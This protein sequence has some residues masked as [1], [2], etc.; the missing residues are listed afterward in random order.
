MQSGYLTIRRPGELQAMPHHWA[1]S[2]S[3][4]CYRV[5]MP[6]TPVE[7]RVLASI[8]EDALVSSLVELIRVPSITGTDAES[9]LQ[10]SQARALEE[11][12]LDVDACLDELISV[13]RSLAL[14]AVR[15]CGGRL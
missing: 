11:L 8:D 12:G 3:G 2:L 7:S 5:G 10:H 6:F 13:T 14:L 9:E 4:R 1:S 15:Q